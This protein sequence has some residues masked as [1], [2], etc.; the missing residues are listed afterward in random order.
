VFVGLTGN[1]ITQEYL[2]ATG[3][4]DVFAMDMNCSL[5]NLAEYAEKYGVTLVPVS[6]L[7]R[8]RGVEDSIDYKPE[9]V[10]EQAEKLI[11]LAIE[12]FK[13]RKDK[14]ARV[15]KRKQWASP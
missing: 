3:A 9:L 4:I 7:V 12:N 10:K 1:W 5:P 8:M 15:P 14:P 13:K 6:R 11:E 2:L